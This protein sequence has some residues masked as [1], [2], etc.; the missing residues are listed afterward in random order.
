MLITAIQTTPRGASIMIT[1]QGDIYFEKLQSTLQELE[2]QFRNYPDKSLL[3]D[4]SGSECGPR[5]SR[6]DNESGPKNA[7]FQRIAI[8]TRPTGE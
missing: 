8:A 3:L 6:S 1:A 4:K 2:T 5:D 7:G